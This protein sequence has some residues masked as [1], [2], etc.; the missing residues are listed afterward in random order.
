MTSAAR[1][2]RADAH[3]VTASRLTARDAGSASVWTVALAA[4][5]WVSAASTLLAGAGVIARHRAASAA[6][7]AA[8]A[9]AQVAVRSRGSPT[10]AI[11]APCN[12]AER[13]AAHNGAQVTGCAVSGQVVDVTVRVATPSLR[14]LGVASVSGRARA[15][16]G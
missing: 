8:L 15:G 12:A 5:V 9:A 11:E 3:A 7:L 10:S 2:R 1:R 6:D 14:Y 16:P 13:I 4:V